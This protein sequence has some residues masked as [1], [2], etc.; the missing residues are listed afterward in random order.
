MHYKDLNSNT[1]NE[2]NKAGDIVT[3]YYGIFLTDA[4]KE[5]SNLL[6]FKD[7]NENLHFVIADDSVTKKDI[8][9]PNING[10]KIE[11]KKYKFEDFGIKQFIDIECF[12]RVYIN[13]FTEV[14]K[15]IADR[16]LVGKE[17]PPRSVTEVINN[18]KSFWRSRIKEILSEEEQI[19][20]ICELMI[21]NKL[22]NINPI[23][24]LNAWKGPFR[25]KYDFIFSEWIF[26][27]KGTRKDRHVHLIN[28]LDQLKPPAGKN[29]VLISFL[30]TKSD[31]T[32]AKSL[33]EWI[34]E[35]EMKSLKNKA[36]MVE[37]FY[38]LLT[39]YGYSRIHIK[40]YRGTKFEIYDGMFYEVNENFPRLTSDHLRTP[41]DRRVSDVSYM[42]NLDDLSGDMFENVLLG[43]YFY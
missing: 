2:L 31:N 5:K 13:E 33:Q 35:I 6:I 38:A 26:E 4:D 32:N 7:E 39:E 19:G 34:E 18:W 42:L 8:T 22:C 25:E 36:A 12:I 17:L 10:L 16:I 21:V 1:W 40:E 28:G 30:A 11:L 15:E 14:I 41:L 29:L 43:K 23:S 24:A 9:D 27:V 37:Q 20:L 3:G